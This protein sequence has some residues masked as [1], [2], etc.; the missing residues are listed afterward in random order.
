MRRVICKSTYIEKV[1][2]TTQSLCE[3][4]VATGEWSGRFGLD[5]FRNHP[6]QDS[7]YI[8]RQYHF[9]SDSDVLTVKVNLANLQADGG[10]EG[11]EIQCDAFTRVLNARWK[12]KAIKAAILIIDSPPHGI[13]DEDRFRWMSTLMAKLGI[14]LTRVGSHRYLESVPNA[15]V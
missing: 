5:A 7:T 15:A 13:E 4:L 6:P 10:G 3:S 9:D 12:D 1:R 8:A 2:D 14:T 11:P